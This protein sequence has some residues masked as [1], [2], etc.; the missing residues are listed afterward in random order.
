MNARC[1]PSR[2]STRPV[3]LTLVVAIIALV[4]VAAWTASVWRA[5][6]A[7]TDTGLAGAGRQEVTLIVSGDTAGWIV[8]CGCTSNQSGGLLRRG[9]VVARERQN[10]S[11]I[12]VDA[13]GASAGTSAYHRLKFTAILRGEL[14]MGLAAHNLGNPE[15]ALGVDELRR[16][17]TELHVPFVSA[18]LRDI[19][20]RLVTAPC[21]IVEAGG[22]RVAFVGVLSPR[23]AIAGCTIDEPRD[24]I[25]S[26]LQRAAGQYDRVVVLAWLTEADLRDL[27]ANLPEAD[28]VIGGPTGQSLSPEAVGRT[29]VASAANK[30]KFLVRVTIPAQDGTAWT[31]TVLE[32]TDRFEDD[33]A[34]VANLQ[35]FRHDLSERDFAAE[36][37]GLAPPLSSGAPPDYRVA[38]SQAC[39]RCHADDYDRWHGSAHAHAWE[40][41][42][43][44]NAHVD[45]ECQRCHA[46]GYG[47]PGGFRTVAA[48]ADRFGVGCESCH[49][50]SLAHVEQLRRRTLM[51]ARDECRRCHDHENSPQFEFA[52]YWKRII[53]GRE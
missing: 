53:H 33:P 18:N 20:G 11:A 35:S 8:P 28:A 26:T 36:T 12:L 22:L 19:A 21:R 3:A 37:T 5:Q 14:L 7:L 50:P 38:G 1:R 13:G 45:P 4:A 9:T 52:S 32:L 10:K 31:G 30:G 43:A 6:P 51:A 41:L 47:L 44:E 15:A 23:E 46:T 16:I 27:A 48:S 24:A 29:L 39:Q 49:G 40:T 42:A 17:E 2:S 25:L 34:Q